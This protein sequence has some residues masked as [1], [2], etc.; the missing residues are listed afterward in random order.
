M[1][2]FLLLSEDE[3]DGVS[4]IVLSIERYR[5]CVCGLEVVV[6]VVVVI[7]IL[8]FLIIA[9][10]DGVKHCTSLLLL[11]K[12]RTRNDNI[13]LHIIEEALFLTKSFISITLIMKSVS[14]HE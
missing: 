6:E 9:D 14:I 11:L 2:Y 1:S 10:N 3:D 4:G 13:H 12:I 5:C 7:G 8:L